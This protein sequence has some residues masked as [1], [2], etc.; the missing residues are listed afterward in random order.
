MAPQKWP[1]EYV[2]AKNLRRLREDKRL[3]E[4][5]LSR[6]SGL[7]VRA[8]RDIEEERYVPKLVVIVRLARALGCT[9]DDLIPLDEVE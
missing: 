9:I 7:T 1:V 6:W 8:Y 2:L 3:S 5:N 4:E